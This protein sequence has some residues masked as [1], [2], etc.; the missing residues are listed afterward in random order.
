MA[1]SSWRAVVKTQ[2]QRHRDIGANT[3]CAKF[4][5]RGEGEICL[6]PRVV[7]KDCPTGRCKL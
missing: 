3:I 6:V 1:E 5:A 4:R 7:N 2:M